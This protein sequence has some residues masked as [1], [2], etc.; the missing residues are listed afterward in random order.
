MSLTGVLREHGVAPF[1]WRK[2]TL[3]NLTVFVC[4][5]LGTG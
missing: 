5:R 4:E 2:E 1:V 3:I